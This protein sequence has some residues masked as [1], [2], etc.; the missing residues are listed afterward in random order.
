MRGSLVK[1]IRSKIL[2]L[3]RGSTLLL[4]LS[5]IVS[6]VG[7]VY[8]CLYLLKPNT[9]LV[10][11][12]PEVVYREGRVLFAPKTPFSPA[13]SGG[14]IPYSDAIVKVNEIPIRNTRDIVVADSKI[15]SFEPFTVE[16]VRDNR[17]HLILEVNPVFNLYRPDW[18]FI[19]IFFV[20]LSFTAFYLSLHSAKNRSYIFLTLACLTYIIFT[21]VKPFYYRSMIT[22]LLVHSG[23]ITAWLIV[24]FGLYFPAKRWNRLLRVVFITVVILL[25]IAFL[26]VRIRLFNLWIVSSTESY[27][28]QFRL[29][30]KISNIT[31]G[32]AYLTYISLLGTAYLKTPLQS[33]K[34]Q[35]EWILAGFMVALPPYFF[36]DQ[37]P[38]ILDHQPGFRLSLGSFANLFLSVFPL[39]V[40]IGLI[41]KRVINFMYF[42]SRYVVYLVLALLFIL[43]F[44][45][46]YAP[47]A[48]WMQDSYGI[49]YRMAGFLVSLFLFVF[50]F[51]LRSV[52]VRLSERLFYRV[53]Y[54]SSVA[55]LSHLKKENRE[56]YL[57]VEELNRQM[58]RSYQR[59]KYRD[60]KGIVRG[61]IDRLRD[62]TRRIS[63]ALMNLNRGLSKIVSLENG[64]EIVKVLRSDL[65]SILL[66]NRELKDFLD[67]IEVLTG[68]SV[69]GPT[70]AD[71][72][73]LVKNAISRFT[74][75]YPGIAI[76]F[77]CRQTVNI[78][79]NPQD[80]VQS[81]EHLYQNAVEADSSIKIHTSC[82]LVDNY[83]TIEVMDD[84]PG[85]LQSNRKRIFYPFFSTKRGHEGIGLYICKTAIE[86]NSGSIE[87]K[88]REGEGALFRIMLPVE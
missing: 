73:L 20:V 81:L 12:F 7:S 5:L 69:S 35:L 37:L 26:S 4:C 63:Q 32:I 51:P 22:N 36:F 1:K 40:V 33:V 34:R 80:L 83:C 87:L 67:H 61:I 50:L 11:N 39:F 9:G 42:L 52:L 2:L 14:L 43:F 17:D 8:F 44:S 78:A 6:V 71:V 68:L 41:K 88:S 48:E 60:V 70:T 85:V 64:E 56:L 53:Y 45:S 76:T 65:E 54:R 84:G 59:E 75:R 49:N 31:E 21:C 28:N 58:V 47:L 66:G 57:M 82:Y 77:E 3:D 24:F 13:V 23:K 38:L 74:S 86:R 16:V 10:V 25:F 29:L 19:L 18:F 79:V 46:L 15:L 27:L 72:S 55:H 30:G 62:P